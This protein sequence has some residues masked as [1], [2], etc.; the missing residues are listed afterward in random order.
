LLQLD[1]MRDVADV[2]GYMVLATKTAAFARRA[3]LSDV[4]WAAYLTPFG[5]RSR[6]KQHRPVLIKS[7]AGTGKTWFVRQ[8]MWT[9][10][11]QMDKQVPFMLSVQHIATA[12]RR[13]RQT[14]W[15]YLTID[16]LIELKASQMPA[17]QQPKYTALLVSQRL[18]V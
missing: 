15:Q 6:D 4:L 16:W 7:D 13:Q 14:H 11:K 12:L 1:E 17:D 8:L 5:W 2:A 3:S 10:G 9:M 18:Q